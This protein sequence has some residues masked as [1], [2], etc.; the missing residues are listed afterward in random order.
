MRFQGLA[1]LAALLSVVSCAYDPTSARSVAMKPGKG[2]VVTLS[3]H[4]DP[5]SRA[6]GDEI[7]NRTC[8]GKKVEV[9]EEGEAVVGSSKRSNTENNN[10]HG[11]GGIKVAGIGFGSPSS[12]SSTDAEERQIT[13]WR[14]TY[15]CK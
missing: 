10:N 7:M 14:V 3:H 13:E 9:V 15:E 11:S 2:G 1:L 5:R 8:A 6:K 4:D 12:T